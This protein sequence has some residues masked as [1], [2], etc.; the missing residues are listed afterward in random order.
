M[1]TK[2]STDKIKQVKKELKKER[3]RNGPHLKADDFN[4][5][6]LAPLPLARNKAKR[7]SPRERLKGEVEVTAL[8][9]ALKYSTMT[10]TAFL[11]DIKGYSEYRRGAMLA[12]LPVE[13]WHKVKE[14]INDAVT[15]DLV[16]RHVDVMAEVQEQ[17]VRASNI[18]LLKAIEMISK[19]QLEPMR[20]KSGKMMMDPTTKKPVYRGFRSIDL[21]NCMNSI[22]KAQEIYRRAMG[23]P[24]DGEGLAQILEK[25]GGNVTNNTQININSDPSTEKEKA[26][27]ALSYDE[28]MTFVEHKRE[29]M[30]EKEK[31][32]AETEVLTA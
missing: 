8:E 18:G 27:A 26:L 32:Q 25:L 19:M 10:V 30:R 11:R 28:I 7:I 2:S 20:D 31:S 5:K 23:L 17:H 13:E 21:L 3:K 12:A 29:K 6:E 15:S 4:P 1:E 9:W 22:S 16:K 14:G 24:N